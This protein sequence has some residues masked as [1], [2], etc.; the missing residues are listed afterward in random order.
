MRFAQSRIIL[1]VHLR[2]FGLGEGCVS[3]LGNLGLYPATT[4]LHFV[5]QFTQARFDTEANCLLLGCVPLRQKSL[6]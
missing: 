2:N 1:A 5:Q 3:I 6:H 4:V